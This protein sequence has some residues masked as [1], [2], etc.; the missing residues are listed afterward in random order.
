MEVKVLFE[1]QPHAGPLMAFHSQSG[2]DPYVTTQTD[3]AGRATVTLEGTGP[4]L[5]LAHG[6]IDYPDQAVC[7]VE[8]F[9]AS[10]TFVMASNQ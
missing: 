8:S 7:D 2:E 9:Y 6:E 4:W 10:L 3:A 5:L 1:G